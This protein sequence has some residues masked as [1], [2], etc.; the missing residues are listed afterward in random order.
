MSD[1]AW[2]DHRAGLK[3]LFQHVLIQKPLLGAVV[4]TSALSA[5]I[6]LVQPGLVGQIIDAVGHSQPL[7]M[8]PWI[9]AGLVV[10]G[11]LL[12]GMLQY[13]IQRTAE[14]AIRFSRRRLVAHV[15]RLPISCLDGM[16]M[17]DLV[18][19]ISNDTTSI[20]DMLSQGLIESIAGIFTLVGSF[21]AML[22]IDPLL[23]II[24]TGTACVAVIIVVGITR[25]IERSSLEL[26]NAIG[27]LASDIDRAL[28]AIRTIRAA[29]A[30]GRE[31]QRVEIQCD[32]AYRI[33]LKLAKITALVSP[34][35]SIAAHLSLLIVL[36]V[37]GL[38]VAMGVLTVAQ[39]ISFIMFAFLL[40]MPL[41]QIFG[42]ISAIG[43]ALGGATR[44]AQIMALPE[45][46]DVDNSLM[47]P[48][49]D[50]D[51]PVLE[52]RKVAFSY[53]GEGEGAGEVSSDMLSNLSFRVGRG[54]TL[55]IV[56]P[57][58][59]GKST[60]LD[61]IA[62]FY[63]PSDGDILFDGR[64]YKIL[65][66]TDIR[67]RLAYVEQEAPAISGTIRDNLTLH[68]SY[69][70]DI[71]LMRMLDEFNLTC[72]I[73]RDPLGLDAEVGE[74]GILL[75]GGERQR[76]ALARALLGN[77]D[78][79]LLDESTSNLDGFNE[80]LVQKLVDLHAAR[81][82]R[83]VVAHRLSTVI[84]ADSILVVDKG[85]IVGEGTHSELLKASGIYR[86]LARTQLVA[87]S[88]SPSCKG[89]RCG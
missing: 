48:S 83:I 70:S 67:S 36:G 15:L 74:H 84:G 9:L 7:G 21:V 31:E 18:S 71:Q 68:T 19:R 14:T 43:E 33:G 75:S 87:N 78:L 5:G 3:E 85:M 45:E 76:L 72:I 62:R 65:A 10:L 44:I 89:S 53:K 81:C 61:L 59:A 55:A 8:L 63:E 57:S 41:G 79:L 42:T 29:N 28:R 47:S 66:R 37:G 69:A 82:A 73:E 38:R 11:A 80:E 51:A 35:S 40:I 4:F 22:L 23:V 30:T 56:G 50:L 58:G 32:R 86:R 17:G 39:L 34:V 26:Q 54:Q 20:R 46:G 1:Q 77:P 12:G 25:L 60:I 27:Q 24:T 6:A 88:A 2:I 16:R 13:L 49:S 64:S 52:F